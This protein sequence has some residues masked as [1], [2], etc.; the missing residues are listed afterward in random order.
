MSNIL[1]CVL[2]ER[3]TLELFKISPLLHFIDA[4]GSY[5]Q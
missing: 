5:T 2:P 1:A 4:N 3:E